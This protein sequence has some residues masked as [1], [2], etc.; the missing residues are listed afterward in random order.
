MKYS[1]SGE[2]C[3]E[4]AWEG[5]PEG[6]CILHSLKPDKD[7]SIFEQ[8]LQGK[9]A[10][11]DYDF[12][13]VF[14]PGRV[15]FA[16]HRFKKPVNFSGAGFASWANLRETEFFE[17]VDFS[18]AKFSQAAIFEKAVF[19]GPVRFENT[20]ISGEADFRGATFGGLAAF[21]HLN[22]P[23]GSSPPPRFTAYFHYVTF[24]PQ[25]RL[26]F[27]DLSLAYVSFLGTDMRRLEFHNVRWHLFRGRQ[28]VYDEIL[29]RQKGGPFII[30][31][32]S[33]FEH[34]LNYE[35]ICARVEQLYRYLKLNYEQAGDQMQAG[36]FHYGEMEM[37]RRANP[38]RRWFPLSWYNLYWVLSGYGEKP[39]RALGWLLGLLFGLGALLTLLG[40]TSAAG[41]PMGLES[42][43][44]FILQQ[45]TLIHPEWA[46]P[47]T[48]GGELIGSLSRLL[49]PAQLALLILAL[50]NSLGRRR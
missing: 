32:T 28:T 8:A 38:W 48:P 49:L 13:E 50:R 2:Y 27:Q 35:G 37:H 31:L 5:D 44:I 30:S 33:W 6:L 26:Q 11:E 47:L 22:E 9:L 43:L 34:G 16:Q 18:Y 21:R 23:G 1:W 20:E 3:S 24:G 15:S 40:L 7:K 12:R 45:A 25:G 29:L 46:R 39:L 19:S 10:R 42:A 4:P 14:F 17:E 41:T 36:D